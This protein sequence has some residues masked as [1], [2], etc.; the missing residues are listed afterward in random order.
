MSK[1]LLRSKIS[2]PFAPDRDEAGQLE[3]GE[4]DIGARAGVMDRVGADQAAGGKLL[5]PSRRIGVDANEAGP[6][7]EA[8]LA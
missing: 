5:L 7:G 1:R 6:V 2:R 8:R 4:A 3:P